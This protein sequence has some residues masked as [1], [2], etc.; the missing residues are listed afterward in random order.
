MQHRL[1]GARVNIA[2]LMPLHRAKI[3]WTSVKE[4][5]S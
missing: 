3:W 4:F 5:L 1:V 2:A